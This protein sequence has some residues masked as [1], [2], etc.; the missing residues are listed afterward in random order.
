MFVVYSVKL[1]TEG[2]ECFSGYT[3]L[4]ETVSPV[5]NKVQSKL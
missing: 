1:A 5:D 3:T 4:T 2:L